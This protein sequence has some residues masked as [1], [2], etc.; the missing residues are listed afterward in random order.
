VIGGW[1]TITIQTLKISLSVVKLICMLW[2][3]PPRHQRYR[4]P[5]ELS[6]RTGMKLLRDVTMRSLVT[7]KQLQSSIAVMGEN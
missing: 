7:L 2:I 1:V 6:Y 3:K 4:H 5:S